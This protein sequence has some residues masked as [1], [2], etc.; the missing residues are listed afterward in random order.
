MNILT[1]ERAS[2][3]TNNLF[4]IVGMSFLSS[5]FFFFNIKPFMSYSVNDLDSSQGIVK[6]YK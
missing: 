3:T 5:P 1:L 4:E 2:V 6:N